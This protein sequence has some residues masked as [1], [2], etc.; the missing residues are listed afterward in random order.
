M[1]LNYKGNK[2]I[3]NKP[4]ID[5]PVFKL[6]YLHPNIHVQKVTCY[7]S[8]MK[9]II[10]AI[11]GLSGCGKSTTAKSVAKALNYAYI[12]SGAMYRAVTLHFLRSGT[13]LTNIAEIIASLHHLQL[14]FRSVEETGEQHIFL[15]GKDVE[16]EIRGM[17]IS[18]L[19]SEVSKIKKVRE[20]LV[21][22]Q[23]ELGDRK[24]VVM[25]GRDIGTVVFPD[26]ELKVFMFAD[27]NIRAERRRK[28]LQ[29]KGKLADLEQIARN[30]K[31]RDYMDTNRKESPLTKASDAVELDTSNLSFEDQVRQILDWARERIN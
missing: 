10:I 6:L 23:K 7:F 29:E 11:D 2:K 31:E 15:N 12:D 21:A 13:A 5:I 17:E 9:K 14:D 16:D 26:A 20:K 3:I 4:I 25:D 30:L 22:I 18:S 27:L 28:E 8:V 1:G 24:G 19:V